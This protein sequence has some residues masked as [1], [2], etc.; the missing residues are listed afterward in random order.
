MM[1]KED[2]LDSTI[3]KKRKKP[4]PN[5]SWQVLQLD[6]ESQFTTDR[7]LKKSNLQQSKYSLKESNIVPTSSSF[8]Q[9]DHM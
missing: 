7:V 2:L 8:T 3:K 4:S 1:Y 9:R 6:E 5:Q